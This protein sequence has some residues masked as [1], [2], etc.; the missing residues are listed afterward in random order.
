MIYDD[1]FTCDFTSDPSEYGLTDGELEIYVDCASC[2]SETAHR[3][4]AC[5][6]TKYTDKNNNYFRT[7]YYY[8]IIC[9]GCKNINFCHISEDDNNSSLRLYPSRIAGQKELKDAH[10]LPHGVFT[11]YRETHA[12]LNNSLHVVAGIGIRAILEAVCKDKGVKGRNLKARITQFKNMG[13]TTTSG[14]EILHGLRFLGNKSA[15]E[16]K[17]HSV[18]ELGVALEVIEH[19]L[20][21]VYI[22]PTK[23]AILSKNT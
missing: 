10:L 4:L 22:L 3:K 14:E 9:Q 5:T 15:H 6:S 16:V 20:L 12:A 21:G 8:I 11:I 18:S 2:N 17:A 19:L 13:I 23:A 7:D 1:I